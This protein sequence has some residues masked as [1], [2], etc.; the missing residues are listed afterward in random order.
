VFYDLQYSPNII[1]VIKSRRIK[2]TGHAAR[3]REGREA[4]R[5]LVLKSRGKRPLGRPK[6]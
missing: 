4:Y 5:V 1:H 2:W 6:H 3:L